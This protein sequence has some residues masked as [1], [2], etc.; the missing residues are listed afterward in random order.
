MLTI[1]AA[2]VTIIGL[3]VSE[4]RVE[5]RLAGSGRCSFAKTAS[6]LAGGR[7]APSADTNMVTTSTNGTVHRAGYCSNIAVSPSASNRWPTSSA[8]RD[9][10]APA[11]MPVT[12][13]WTVSPR[14]QMANSTTGASEEAVKV[15]TMATRSEERRVGKESGPPRSAAEE[16][17]TQQ[18]D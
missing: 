12:A 17:K 16:Q 2:P 13:P 10:V 3:N 6:V 7:W 4:P 14:H 1:A 9:R 15:K 5:I 18:Q 11:S 8:D